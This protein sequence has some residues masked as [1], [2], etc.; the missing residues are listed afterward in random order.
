M[1]VTLCRINFYLNGWYFAEHADILLSLRPATLSVFV[2]L[3]GPSPLTWNEEGLA[4]WL[5][6]LGGHSIRSEMTLH[7]L[8]IVVY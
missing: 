6:L 7:N 4:W 1:T 5:H 3:F 8:V 2:E